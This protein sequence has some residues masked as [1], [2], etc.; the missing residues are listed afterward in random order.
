MI[1]FPFDFSAREEKES[2]ARFFERDLISKS[3]QMPGRNAGCTTRCR[4]SIPFTRNRKSN[5]KSKNYSSAKRKTKWN[6]VTW[7][8]IILT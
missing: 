8:I 5:R 3:T 4:D 2:Q 7:H 1:F 6:I